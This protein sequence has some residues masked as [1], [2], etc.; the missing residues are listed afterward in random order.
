VPQS[1]HKLILVSLS[2]SYTKPR[3]S[4]NMKPDIWHVCS[5]M[6]VK[7]IPFFLVLTPAVFCTT[8]APK[9]VTGI[10]S[11][12]QHIDPV[13]VCARGNVMFSF[14][15]MVIMASPGSRFASSSAYVVFWR[16]AD[17]LCHEYA[18]NNFKC[19]FSAC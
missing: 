14:Q 15:S 17:R 4:P 7:K 12:V 5:K 2:F 8:D 10:R 3:I 11:L 6:D 1:D 18:I 19:H 16:S 13:S 9:Q